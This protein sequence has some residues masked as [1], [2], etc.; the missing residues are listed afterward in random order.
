MTTTHPVDSTRPSMGTIP[1]ANLNQLIAATDGARWVSPWEP[2][3]AGDASRVFA[4][5]PA[6][7]ESDPPVAAQLFG[8]VTTAGTVAWEVSVTAER[9]AI[10]ITPQ[11][12]RELARALMAVAD[13]WVDAT[14]ECQSE[15]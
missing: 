9:E 12:T 11:Q 13:Q 4:L 10:T 3:I 7:V 6:R 5:P 2:N 14:D 8:E 1:N 15:V